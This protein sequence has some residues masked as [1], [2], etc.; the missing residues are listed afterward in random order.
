MKHFVVATITVGS[1]L[2][3]GQGVAGA[4]VST[5]AGTG[6][7][8]D[9]VADLEAKAHHLRPHLEKL[10]HALVGQQG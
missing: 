2:I 5:P 9:M 1:M 6:S 4:A 3:L 8:S 7:A 10:A